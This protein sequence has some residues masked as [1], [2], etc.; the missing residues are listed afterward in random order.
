MQLEK[1]NNN[2]NLDNFLTNYKYLISADRATLQEIKNFLEDYYNLSNKENLPDEF[3]EKIRECQK[4]MIERKK[5]DR[6][7]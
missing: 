5:C 3:K 4:I 6:S 2:N 7:R 1:E